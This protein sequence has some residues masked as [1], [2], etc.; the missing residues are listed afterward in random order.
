MSSSNSYSDT[1]DPS[2]VL[3]SFLNKLQLWKSILRRYQEEEILKL[4]NIPSSWLVDERSKYLNG[5]NLEDVLADN[6]WSSDEL[7]M[8]LSLPEALRLFSEYMF[9]PGLEELFL[10]ADGGH[11]QVIYSVIRVRDPGLAQELW[12]RIEEGEKSFSEL[13]SEFGEG[14]EA[15]KKGLLGP[16]PLGSIEPPPLK[17]ILRSLKASK[18][19]P[20]TQL[21]EWIILVRLEQLTK[22]RFDQ[23]MRTF[24]LDQ[25]LN[26]FLNQR[27]ED[28]ILGKS[29]D[30]LE[31]STTS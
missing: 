18:V 7:D 17:S 25:Q 29:L 27:V 6:N 14:P 15:K 23:K 2:N 8:H 11:D 19:T 9:S 4:V 22:S 16:V 30:P 13:A 31:Y 24:L 5:S 10:S 12:I 3:V 26:I 20:P 28:I 21:G 1:Q